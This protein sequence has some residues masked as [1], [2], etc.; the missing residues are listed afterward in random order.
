VAPETLEFERTTYRV[1]WQRDKSLGLK[2]PPEIVAEQGT[3]ITVVSSAPGV[4]VRTP[5]ID[6]TFDEDMSFYRGSARVEGRTL[7][8]TASITAQLGEV[9]A[10]THVTVTRKEEGPRFRIRLV[11]EDTGIYRAL[12]ETEVDPATGEEVRV[13]KVSGR[14]PALRSVLEVYTVNSPPA[15]LVIAEAVADVAARVVVSQLYRL[16]RGS[17]EF[18]A[19]RIYLEHYRRVARFLPKAQRSLLADL[20]EASGILEVGVQAES[21]S[22]GIV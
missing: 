22:R 19:E 20:D 5:V 4:V 17:E 11:D 12:S 21:V 13:L 16:R 3:R 8:V 14:H 2:A 10:S 15:R 6:L 18:S 9:H 7:G 1:S